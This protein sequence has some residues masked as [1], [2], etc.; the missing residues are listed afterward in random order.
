MVIKN[1][2]DS[3]IRWFNRKFAESDND[4]LKTQLQ[5]CKEQLAVIE[6]SIAKSTKLTPRG[7]ELLITP[8]NQLRLRI[9]EIETELE[10]RS[11]H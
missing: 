1:P 9:G 5:N 8:R 4:Q 10:M 3:E 2:D 7:L 6:A 11:R